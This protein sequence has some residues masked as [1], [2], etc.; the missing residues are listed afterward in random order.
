MIGA[1][2]GIGRALVPRL[3]AADHA[4]VLAGRCAAPLE[5]LAAQH[6]AAVEALLARRPEVRLAVS[7]AGSMLLEPAAATSACELDDARAGHVPAGVRLDDVTND[8]LWWWPFTAI[9]HAAWRGREGA[10][11]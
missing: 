11:R 3:S 5:E 10:A 7:L 2:G 4:L 1:A 6:G 9:L 8:L